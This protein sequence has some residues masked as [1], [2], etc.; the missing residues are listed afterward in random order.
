MLQ[1]VAPFFYTDVLLSM[2]Y[3]Q[4]KH[5]E[6]GAGRKRKEL[7]VPAVMIQMRKDSGESLS[8]IAKSYELSR[9]TLYRL[10]KQDSE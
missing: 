4:K 8:D 5:N 2:L 6:R 9:S 3:P 10:L 7:P 1:L